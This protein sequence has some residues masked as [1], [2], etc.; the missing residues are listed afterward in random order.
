MMADTPYSTDESN[1][2]PRTVRQQKEARARDQ[3]AR[4]ILN[5]PR[6]AYQREVPAPPPAQT[7]AQRPAAQQPYTAPL[8]DTLAADSG[9]AEAYS[10]A[11]S[12]P[13]GEYPA[14]AVKRFD[15]PFT[16]LVGFFLKC[17]VAAI[18]ASLLLGAILWGLGHLAQ[19]YLPWLIKM[20]VLI[21]FPG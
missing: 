5:A 1:D 7:P 18:P 15:V 20:Q 17:A 21:T 11:A 19:T 2:L 6:P 14:T 9:R 8:S 3:M 13:P 16:H 12:F 10:P 4:E